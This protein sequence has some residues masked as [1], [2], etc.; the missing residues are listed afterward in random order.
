MASPNSVTVRKISI[1][2][3]T[4]RTEKVNKKYSC[5]YHRPNLNPVAMRIV[6]GGAGL[7]PANRAK[8][9]R[10]TCVA[11]TQSTNRDLIQLIDSYLF[12]MKYCLT[13]EAPYYHYL[14]QGQI[15][16]NILHR[17]CH[18]LIYLCKWQQKLTLEG[19]N[20]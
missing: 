15:L 17:Q 7:N 11:C 12:F 2:Q 16:L 13:K 4:C 10:A 6:G 8:K 1:Y 20:H 5:R 3:S 19:A 14:L 18:N 9:N